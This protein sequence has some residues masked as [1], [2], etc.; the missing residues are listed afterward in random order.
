M[1]YIPPEVVAQVREMDLLTYLRTY[2]PQELVHFGGGTYC[3]R[4]HD[5][6]KISNGKWCWFSRGI[7]GYSALDYLI[8]VKEMPFTQA[9]E[10]IM[11][12]VAVSPPAYTPA[13]S[14]PKEKVLLLP[15]ANR[16]ATHAVEYLHRRGIDYDLIDF[17]ISMGRLY[18]SY[19]YHNVVFVELDRRGKPRYANLR[20]IGS[21]FIGDANGSDKL[22]FTDYPDVVNV[23]QMC[24]MLGGICDKT[25]YRLLKSGKIKSF[26]VGRHY[27]I[28]KLNILEY[29]ELIDKSTA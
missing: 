7:G 3:T 11:G 13:P 15:K 8:K 18:E 12:N 9:V 10:A 24:E 14:K 19:P 25:A 27:R 20:G 6:L 28:P 26:I 4:E 2:E 17:C 1:P 16:C 5:S 21:D 22:L 29:L 23:E